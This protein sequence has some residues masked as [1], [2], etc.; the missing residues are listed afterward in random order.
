MTRNIRNTT[1]HALCAV[2][3]LNHI[4]LLN[5]EQRK[6]INAQI[7][8]DDARKFMYCFVPKVACSN[9]KRVIKYMN[10]KV[11][12]LETPMKMDHHKDLVFLGDFSDE[13][14]EYRL[15]NYFKFMFVRDPTERLLSAYRNKF[16]EN[17]GT[18]N[19][20]YAPKI[21][22]KYRKPGVR[23]EGDDQS[24]IT[25]EEYLR[26]LVDSDT[27]RMDPHWRPMWEL[28]QPCSINYDFIGS[29][30]Q[31]PEDAAL[32]LDR[33]RGDSDV[34]FPQRQSWYKPTTD[35]KI[36]TELQKVHTQYL[37]QVVDKYARDYMLFGYPPPVAEIARPKL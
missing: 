16:G 1:I 28:C 25:F 19:T 29:F 37:K 35:D 6:T 22:A 27:R 18:Y 3:E 33:V 4:S 23:I 15:R 36:S 12:D 8:V 9:W 5:S 34:Y 2:E 17:I 21:I 13:E 24:R 7:L 30:E 11:P 26:F 10:G 31:L 20:K 14:V 32:V